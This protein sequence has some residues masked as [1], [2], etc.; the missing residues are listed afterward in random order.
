M[1]ISGPLYRVAAAA[2][3]LALFVTGCGQGDSIK[4]VKTTPVQGEV[5]FDGNPIPGAL[6]V[7]HPASP[8]NNGAPPA[9]ATV[10]DDGVF[11]LTTYDSGD[12]IPPGD[13]KVTVEWRPLVENGGEFKAGPNRLPEK[14][15]RPDTTDL[16]VNIA[17]GTTKL[18][19]LQ[20]R[21]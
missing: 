15:A 8:G 13:Y 17:E 14:Y 5:L 18:P 20:I 19:P 12:G 10:Q 11:H 6:V 9:R 16:V 7:F 21:R 3:L 2:T 1:S 4:R